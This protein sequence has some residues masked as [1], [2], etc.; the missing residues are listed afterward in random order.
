MSDG[1][2]SRRR[3]VEAIAALRTDYA[4]STVA[5]INR[6]GV[7]VQRA[8]AALPQTTQSPLFTIAGGRVG[9]TMFI[10]EVTTVLQT[11]ANN[12]KIVYAPTGAGADT[13]LCAVLDTTAGAV[14]TYYSLPNSVSSAL[15]SG[16]RRCHPSVAVLFVLE[17]GTIDLSCAASSTGSIKWSCWYIPIDS[18]ATIVA[19]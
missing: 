12:T 8:T 19:A 9:V 10:G 6:L 17:A 14:G 15:S 13:D 4:A 16:I 11:Q 18:G 5:R 3:L 7:E 1:P 2:F